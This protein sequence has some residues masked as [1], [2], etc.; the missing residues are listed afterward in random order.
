MANG[1]PIALD[2]MGGDHGAPPNV[3]GALA[4]VREDGAKVI[5]VGDE[6]VLRAELQR[7]GAAS[8]LDSSLFIR[9]APEVVTMDEKPSQAVRKKKGSSMRVAS[10]LV[11]N[12]E[13]SAVVSAGNSGAMM[14]VALFVFGRLDG[15]VR[16]AIATAFP[17][18]SKAGFSVLIDAGANTDC[19]PEH[20]FQF[21][22]MGDAFLRAA[23]RNTSPSIG[24]MSN[25]TEDSKG[26]DLTRGALALLRK[27]DLNV[28]GHIEGNQIL[29]GD[30]DVVVTDGFTG[31]VML[32]TSEAVA[33]FVGSEIKKALMNANVFVKL[34]SL[35]AKRTLKGVA[36]KF[37]AR[38]FGAAPLLGL[39]APAFIAHGNSDAY[40]IRRS[41]T[42]AQNH[43]AADM[44]GQIQE[45]I[46]RWLH[47]IETPP[48]APSKHA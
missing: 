19:S 33:H 3:E 32:K 18:P 6:A 12:G 27:T 36:T 26:T 29:S 13:A 39:A 41:I 30:I 23:F 7:R 15:V 2:A 1:L 14:A 48:A 24:I 37:D 25:G 47:L 17:S 35:V 9:H 38:E 10:D 22:L 42:A 21:G 45:L 44:T 43:A 8:L 11:K 5:L 28:V 16:P 46:Q 31:N 34:A 20:L 40:A 4:A